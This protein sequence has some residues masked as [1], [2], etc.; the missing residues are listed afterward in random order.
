MQRRVYKLIPDS[1][2]DRFQQSQAK[3]QIAGGGFGNGK[4][5]GA[6]IKTLAVARDYP[7]ANILMARSTYPK[8][9]DTL[10]KE[11]LKWCPRHW[12]KSFPMSNNGT[13]TCVLINGTELNFRYVDQKG[14]ANGEGGTSN[15]LSATYD[16]VVVDQIEDPEITEKD[17]DDLLGRLRGMAVYQGN[18]MSMPRT[19]PRW[20]IVTC[21]PTRNWVYKTLVHPLH[22]YQNTGAITDKL[23]CLRGENHKPILG[24]DNKPQLMLEL[25]EGSTYENKHVL[26]ADFIQTLESRYTGQMRERFLLGKWA[27]YEGLVYPMFDEVVHAIRST[28]I[29]EHLFNIRQQGY[30]INWIEGYDYGL[31]VPMCYLLAYVDPWNNIIMCD[32]IYERELSLE[33]QIQGMIDIRERWGVPVD[34]QVY[35]DPSIFKRGPQGKKIVGR[36]IAD[37]LWDKGNGLRMIRGNSNIANGI[38]KVGALWN[39]VSAHQNPFTQEWGAPH[40]YYSSDM[41]FIGAEANNYIWRVNP[42]GERIDEPRDKDDH[43]MDT[44]KYMCSRIPMPSLL[45]T[46]P[47]KPPAP[48]PTTWFEPPDKRERQRSWRYN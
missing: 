22:T 6:C 39:I 10:R 15:L 35:A 9:N 2:Q 43:A 19:G 36:S 17:F 4:T 38:Q 31:A 16:L 24:D 11:F 27:A 28:D 32:G 14:A 18:D 33:K 48:Y 41:E 26:E 46:A 45:P 29:E 7:G 40:M 12:I 37:I 23:L 42:S 25:F 21:N 1:M 44:I 3:V 34:K 30:K 47:R 20:L 13:N 5:S 8:L